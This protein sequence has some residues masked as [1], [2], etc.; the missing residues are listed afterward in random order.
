EFRILKI[1]YEEIITED[2]EEMILDV[3]GS[4]EPG[5]QQVLKSYRILE[6]MSA[7]FHCKVSGHPLPKISWFKDGRRIM[8]GGRYQIE[9]LQD[10]RASLRIPVVLP[11]DEGVYS[12]FACNFS[13]SRVCS[14]KLYVEP[15]TPTGAPQY[16]AEPEAKFGPVHFECRLTPIGDPAMVVEWLHDGKPL[17]AANRLRMVNEFGYCSLDYEVA[18]SRDSG[19]ITCRA[20]N[21]HGVDQTSATLIVKDEKSLVEESQVYE[22]E[23]ARYRCRVTGYPQPKVNWYLNGQ[24]IRKSKRFRLRYD[25]IYYLEIVDCKSYDSGEVK[26]TAENPEAVVEHT[27]KLEV[28]Q[29]EDFRSVLR[30]APEPKVE[31]PTEHGRVSFDVVKADKPHEGAQHTALW[32]VC[33]EGELGGCDASSPHMLRFANI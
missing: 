2:G 17:A 22:G 27:V 11:E 23:I 8:P 6:G 5:F 32:S 28:Q 18:Y 3:A 30:R 21:K 13:G 16:M 24:L 7:T 31:A 19:V 29:K 15:S 9:V 10:G 12:V 1:T 33:V 4:V 20:T 25:G 14:G 26:V